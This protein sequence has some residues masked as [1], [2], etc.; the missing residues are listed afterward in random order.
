MAPQTYGNDWPASVHE[1]TW[2]ATE[3]EAG[4]DTGSGDQPLKSLMSDLTGSVQDLIRGEVA[5]AKEEIGDQASRAA[6]GAAIL[7]AAGVVGFVAL[8]LAAFAAA[9]GLA[10]TIPTGLAFLAVALLFGMIGALLMT[11]GRQRL[12]SVRPVP[13]Q[14]IQTLRQ[15]LDV[16]KSSFARG[17]QN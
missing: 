16:A 13:R 4:S 14:T 2:G 3:S 10:E 15:G 11:V 17:A 8:L 1:P 12:R 5:L 6:K 7:A 9:W